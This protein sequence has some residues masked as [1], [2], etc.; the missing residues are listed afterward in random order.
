MALSSRPTTSRK[1]LTIL[2]NWVPYPHFPLTSG[3]MWCHLRWLLRHNTGLS[4]HLYR[5]CMWREEGKW[6]LWR[7]KVVLPSLEVWGMQAKNF[8]WNNRF[9]QFNVTLCQKK[10]LI[11]P[12]FETE[13]LTLIVPYPQ[14]KCDVTSDDYPDTIQDCHYTCTDGAC[15]GKKGNDLCEDTKW[16]CPHWKHEVNR[17]VPQ[18]KI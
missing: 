11:S 17:H 18:T 7:H 9:H 3:Q 12:S 14:G 1:K 5:W 10:V 4:L 13:S 8:L 16:S 15:D 6:C 2:W